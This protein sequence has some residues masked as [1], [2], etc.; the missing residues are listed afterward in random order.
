MRD[1]I[2][3]T[4]I[5]GFFCMLIC[6]GAQIKIPLFPIPVTLQLFAVNT[7]ILAQRGRYPAMTLIG[8]AVLGLFGLPVFAGGGGIAYVLTPSFGY[9]LGFIA[10]ATVSSF[11]AQCFNRVTHSVINYAVIYAFGLSYFYALSHFYLNSD[12]TISKMLLTGFLI[13]LPGDVISLAFSVVLLGVLE[14][15]KLIA[16]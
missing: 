11:L 8:Y 3:K 10:A 5:A 12:I 9:I 4:I 2:R 16:S 14:R 1:N 7:S 13:F 15:R 6:I